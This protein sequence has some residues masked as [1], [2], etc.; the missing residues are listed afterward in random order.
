MTNPYEELFSM[1][2]K[3]MKVPPHLWH[4]LGIAW[5]GAAIAVNVMREKNRLPPD[6]EIEVWPTILQE[7]ERL[8]DTIK[9]VEDLDAWDKELKE[10]K[11]R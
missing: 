11:G 7:I 6:F 4:K 8:M 2:G 10:A 3:M 9:L 5:I 1:L